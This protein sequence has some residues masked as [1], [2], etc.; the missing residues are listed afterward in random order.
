MVSVLEVVEVGTEVSVV[1]E[2]P[3]AVVE[4]VVG[5]VVVV[6]VGTVVVVVVVLGAVTGAYT[7]KGV[8]V[9]G[10]GVHPGGGFV[11][12]GT[13]PATGVTIGVEGSVGFGGVQRNGSARSVDPTETGEIR[14]PD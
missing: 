6:E 11:W 9:P 10:L 13:G 3:G 4:V 2:S 14:P 1:V 12:D 7:L 8:D 5:T